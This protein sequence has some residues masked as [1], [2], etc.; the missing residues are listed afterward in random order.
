VKVATRPSATTQKPME[1]QDSNDE[2]DEKG[3]GV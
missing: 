2:N 3:V 1:I